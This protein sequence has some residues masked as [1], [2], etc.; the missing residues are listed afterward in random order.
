MKTLKRKKRSINC[1]LEEET[2]VMD[3]GIMAILGKWFLMFDDERG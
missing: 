1:S 2:R 3:G